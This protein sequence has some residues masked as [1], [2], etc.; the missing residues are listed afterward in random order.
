MR[1]SR[2]TSVQYVICVRLDDAI[3]R[4]GGALRTATALGTRSPGTR[5]VATTSKHLQLKRALSSIQIG[6]L[7]QRAEIASARGGHDEVLARHAFAATAS[8]E[9][10]RESDKHQQ[11]R[12]RQRNTEAIDGLQ[13]F[14]E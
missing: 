6:C 3:K 12:R 4:M 14:R 13:L 2:A 7:H 8:R 5:R 11:R 9:Y 1:I 10:S